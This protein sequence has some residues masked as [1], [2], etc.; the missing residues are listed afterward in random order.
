LEVLLATG[1]LLG[2]LIVLS[3]L[4][5]IGGRRVRD[6]E[7]LATAERICQTKIHEILAGLADPEPLEDEPV[8]DES[9]WLCSIETE[10]LEQPGLIAVRVTARQDLPDQKRPK[11]FTLVRWVREAKSPVE[12]RSGADGRPLPSGFRGGRP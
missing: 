12:E 3:E 1:I 9:G 5:G 7:A 11:R 8:E 6:A 10:S 4:A 2:C